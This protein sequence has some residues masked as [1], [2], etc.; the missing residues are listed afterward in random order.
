MRVLFVTCGIPGI[1]DRFDHDIYTTLK[2]N[3]ACRVR[4]VSP[5]KLSPALIKEFR[6]QVFLVVHG[7]RTPLEMVRY[8]HRKGS[9]TVLWLLED[10]F[11]ID[12]HR[13][14]VKA[15][16]YVF[17]NERQA[18]KEYR[19]PRVFYLPFACN[20]RVHKSIAVPSKYRSDVCFVG[21]GFPNR[22]KILN[23]LVPLLKNLNVKLIGNWER[24]GKLHP[25]L[26]RFIVPVV[27][28]FTEIQRYYN[29]AAV[30]LNI[31]RDPVN[32][33]YGNKKKV[34]STSPNDRA[35]IL[36]GCGAFQ[37]VDK[38][39][40]DLWACFVE[41]RELVG[42]SNSDDLAKKIRFYL[43]RPDLRKQIGRAAQKRAYRR[44]TYRRRLQELFQ[45]IG[46]PWR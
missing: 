40:P 44:H 30:N 7:S 24:W 35:F 8:A 15:Y 13:M 1:H 27:S 46:K 14:M 26:R 34:K 18:V 3:P 45:K 32:P 9:T 5:K 43:K 36:A 25:K 42:F 28:N 23:A 11:E 37:L 31:H 41:G 38:S 16:D 4:K 19:R 2:E 29:G 17:T 10:P 39:C 20:P 12:R 22:I 6:P 33:Q 21:M